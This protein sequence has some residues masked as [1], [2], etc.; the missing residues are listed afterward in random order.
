MNG[1]A[2][3]RALFTVSLVAVGTTF[4]QTRESMAQQVSLPQGWQQLSTKDFVSELRKL[5]KDAAL[6]LLSKEEWEAA[7]SHAKTLFLQ[8]DVA[9]T[10]LD[11]QTIEGL[12]YLVYKLVDNSVNEQARRALISRQD[13]WTGKS[14][15]E[16]RSKYI[17]MERLHV[18]LELRLA[19]ARRWVAAGGKISEVPKADLA[20]ET[21]R[22]IFSDVKAITGSFTVRWEGL[23]NAPETGAYK[24]FINPINVNS[25]GPGV[26]V[27]LS[28]NVSV[29]GQQVINATPENWANESSAVQLNAGEPVALQVNLSV[30][31]H[32]IPPLTLHALLYWQGPG[33]AKS[34]VTTDRLRQA[35]TGDPGLKATYTW[36]DQ[37]GQQQTI[38]RT[39]RTIDLAWT[40]TTIPVAQDVSLS[41][42]AA[43]TLW[44][45]VSTEEYLNWL[46]TSGPEVK[47]H[48]YF[49]EIRG[50]PAGL[51][52]AR[53]AAFL[54][55]LLAHPAL[56]SVLHQKD[57]INLYQGFRYGA[58]DKSL[59]V[60]GKWATQHADITCTISPDPTFEGEQRDFYHRL[61]VCVTRELPSE[62]TRL[63]SEYLELPDG[64][65]CLPVA[66]T[67]AYSYLGRG[68]FNE[69]VAY[70][71]SKLADNSI[72]GDKRVNWLLAR[73]HAEEIQQGEPNLEYI[74]KARI[75]DGRGYLVEAL[76]IVESPAI[77]ARIARELSGRLAWT[78]QYDAARDEIQRTL[79]SLPESDRAPLTTWQSELDALATAN[80][81]AQESRAAAAK[82]SYLDTLRARREQAAAAGNT[83]AVERYDSLINAAGNQ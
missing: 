51:S 67:L 71:E 27:R 31:A 19:E 47:W 34:I 63:R 74:P 17:M 16:I 10:D 53:R 23:I 13:D 8:I 83:E 49:R 3:F 12:H 76:L 4:G 41:E 32:E 65:C 36:T 35:G 55:K 45:E 40:N 73:A 2:Q 37:N 26:P 81:Q 60:F 39:D 54:G 80:S 28:M 11:Y 7:Q 43:D 77:K 78:Q 24:F 62:V 79:E 5:D 61:A 70:L 64:R 48:P 57:A 46:E 33:I 18:P 42:Q 15:S 14:Y 59:E 20:N 56:I 38:T 66:Y 50:A 69:W 72:T 6:S 44:Q 82:Q 9:M 25:P 30:E 21:V 29:E 22:Q 1:I 68:K 58:E 75:L 52:S